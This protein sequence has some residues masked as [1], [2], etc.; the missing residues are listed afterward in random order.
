MR[1]WSVHPAHLDRQALIACWR[2]TLLAQAVLAGRTKGYTRHPQLLRFRAAPHGEA[3]IG[4]YLT[5]L[6]DEADRRGYRFDRSRI[7]IPRPPEPVL[8][9]TDGQIG[10]EWEHLLAKLARRSP[11][12]WQRWHGTLPRPHPLFQVVPGPIADWER[13]EWPSVRRGTGPA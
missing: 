3:L 4:A 8:S 10:Y 5:G 6:A 11:E 12:E 2:E 9:V 1:I 13:P 7:L